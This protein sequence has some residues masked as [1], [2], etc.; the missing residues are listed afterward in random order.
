VP[1]YGNSVHLGQVEIENNHVVVDLDCGGA[2]PFPIR[3]N[4]HAVV[5]AFQALPHESG[6]SFIIFRDKNAHKVNLP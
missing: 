2:S 5:F 4:I 6:Q 3:K 1:Q